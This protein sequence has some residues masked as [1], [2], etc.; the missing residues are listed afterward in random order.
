MKNSWLDEQTNSNSRKKTMIFDGRV[1]WN[2]IAHVLSAPDSPPYKGSISVFSNIRKRKEK[3]IKNKDVIFF[4]TH[5]VYRLIPIYGGINHSPPYLL[6]FSPLTSNKH[7]RTSEEDE[8]KKEYGL[9][10]SHSTE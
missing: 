6:G 2:N 7:M 10:W 8:R 9:T 5:K 4:S 1:H 3:K